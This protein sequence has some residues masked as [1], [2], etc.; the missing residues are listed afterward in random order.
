VREKRREERKKTNE[1]QLFHSFPRNHF[2]MSTS[3]TPKKLLFFFGSTYVLIILLIYI[4]IDT[5]SPREPNK[6][7]HKKFQTN[8]ANKR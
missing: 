6:L 3:D 5:K 4:N 7:T 2:D 8:V 1:E